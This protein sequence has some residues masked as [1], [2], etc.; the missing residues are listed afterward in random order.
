ML[1]HQDAG[2]AVGFRLLANVE[3]CNGGLTGTRWQYE[4]G[5]AVSVGLGA[6]RRHGLLLIVPGNHVPALSQRAQKGALPPG[7]VGGA[8]GPAGGG[9]GGA[10]P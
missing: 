9:A 5:V 7:A 4:N 8:V 10:E 1:E 2:I 3:A 6:G